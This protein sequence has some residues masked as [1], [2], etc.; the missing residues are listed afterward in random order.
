MFQEAISAYQSRDFDRAEQTLSILA[1]SQAIHENAKLEIETLAWLGFLQKER[2]KYSDAKRHIE[3]AISRSK[4]SN[5]SAAQAVQLA[6]LLGDVY[7]DSGDYAVAIQKYRTALQACRD[8]SDCGI[9]TEARIE[10]RLADMLSKS[11]KNSEALE[12]YKNALKTQTRFLGK[13][14]QD[15]INTMTGLGVLY[16][17]SDQLDR[18]ETLILE[19]YKNASKECKPNERT[20]LTCMNNAAFLSG[21]KDELK[22]SA[23]LYSDCLRMAEEVY[24]DNHPETARQM[25]NLAVQLERL[26]E[27]K[28]AEILYKKAIAI[29]ASRQSLDSPSLRIYSTNLAQFSGRQCATKENSP[30]SRGQ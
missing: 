5:G 16:T 29:V 1:A 7:A 22:K 10:S 11:G 12:L 17:V 6:V 26:G 13:K 24:G 9:L 14:N 20:L 4:A 21:R 3:R 27:F 30:L 2:A 19:A 15:T 8:G 23:E 25:N 28:K 18:A